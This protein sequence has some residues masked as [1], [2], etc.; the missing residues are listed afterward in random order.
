M[1]EVVPNTDG[2]DFTAD[3]TVLEMPWEHNIIQTFTAQA[4]V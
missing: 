4:N 2:R 1:H 3:N